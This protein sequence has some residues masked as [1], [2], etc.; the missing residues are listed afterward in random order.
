MNRIFWKE[1]VGLLS[2]K[3][4]LASLIAVTL[5]SGLTLGSAWMAEFGAAGRLGVANTDA[6][7]AAPYTT[8]STAKSVTYRVTV[9]AD[10]KTSSA[11]VTG[12]TVAEAVAEAGV[13]LGE[14]DELS[15]DATSLVTA[16]TA[17]TVTRVKL[18]FYTETE[19]VP[20][21]TTIQRD[22]TMDS[23]TEKVSQAGKNGQKEITYCKRY[24]D[25]ELVSTEVSREEITLQPLT[26]ILIKGTKPVVSRI[27][28]V[29][30]ITLELDAKGQPINYKEMHT[31]SAT[32][33]TA[34]AGA[35]TSI[36]MKAQEG[37][38][39]VDPDLI[40]YRSKLYIVS[41]D[42]KFVYGYAV[43]GDTGGAAMR[44]DIVVDVFYDTY[45][46]CAMF[47]RRNMNVY[48]I[49]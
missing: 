37:V 17:V 32:A 11:I 15:V 27:I 4:M 25:G 33:Y 49:G 38:V 16:D 43:A 12:G 45:E 2:G 48:I 40:P 36:G 18:E 6:P 41:P 7:E 20:Y 5:L 46:E 21:P 24:E 3:R 35:G 23:G 10:G 14:W 39:A 9:T 19:L 22:K 31:G 47:G 28:E 44:G 34:P 1:F 29:G 42:G 13:D 26:Q 8:S 30:G